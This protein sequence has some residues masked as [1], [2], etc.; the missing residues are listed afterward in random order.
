MPEIVN[1]KE[2]AQR[3]EKTK[4]QIIEMI[5]AGE[6]PSAKFRETHWE[7]DFEEIKHLEPK[8]FND[9][10]DM[11][12]SKLD[13]RYGSL[14]YF[15]KEKEKCLIRGYEDSA[16]LD[17]Y[18]ILLTLVRK[19]TI[20]Y[21]D[22]LDDEKKSDLL[23]Q[24]TPLNNQISSIRKSLEATLDKGEKEEEITTLHRQMIE[25][26]RKFIRGRIGEHSLLCKGCGTVV[27]TEGLP[28]WAIYREEKDGERYHF[29][30]S[31]EMWYCLKK[32]LIKPHLV[33][34]FLRTSI[35]GVLYTANERNEEELDKFSLEEEEK[36]LKELQVSYEKIKM[37][38][39]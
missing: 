13:D 2:A 30:F 15:R 17:N 25:R 28:H 1:I 9:T 10:D 26:A 16:L 12:I 24:L 11:L 31:P 38:R 33:A 8:K 35:E 5:N 4:D 22:E 27:N 32:K 19:Q 6:I 37:E 20:R 36:A 29:V 21:Q 39:G 34:F 3:L 23:K 14:P 7:L 18:C